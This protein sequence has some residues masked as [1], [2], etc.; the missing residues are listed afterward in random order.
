MNKKGE[1]ALTIRSANTVLRNI[2]VELS[3]IQRAE[4]G[5]A[6]YVAHVTSRDGKIDNNKKTK[7]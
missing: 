5:A 6:D 4:A 2:T 1:P 7:D 3:V